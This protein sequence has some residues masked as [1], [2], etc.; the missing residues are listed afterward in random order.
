LF[1]FLLIVQS[2]DSSRPLVEVENPITKPRKGRPRG[3][4]RIFSSVEMNQ[5]KKVRSIRC[6]HCGEQGH[7]RRSCEK[8]QNSDNSSESEKEVEQSSK[9]SEKCQPYDSVSSNSEP[10]DQT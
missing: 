5:E 2:S 4:R 1:N 7:N 3:A 6:T 9:T 8:R 10:E